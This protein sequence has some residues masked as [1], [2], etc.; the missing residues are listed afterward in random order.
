MVGLGGVGRWGTEEFFLASIAGRTMY[1]ICAVKTNDK[2]YYLEHA[3][4]SLDS[5]EVSIYYFVTVIIIMIIP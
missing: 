1:A 2:A 5:P 3:D 4:G